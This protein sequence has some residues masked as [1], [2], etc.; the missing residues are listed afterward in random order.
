MEEAMETIKSES[1]RRGTT[2]GETAMSCEKYREAL[3]DAAAA[4]EQVKADLPKLMP[5]DAGRAISTVAIAVVE[6]S[7]CDAPARAII[8]TAQVAN[9]R[10]AKRRPH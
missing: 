3:I 1:I 8:C 4:G 9:G 10:K 7:H 6:T 5:P 2:C